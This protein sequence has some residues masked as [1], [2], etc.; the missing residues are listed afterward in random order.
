MDRLIF[1]AMSATRMLAQRQESIANNLANANTNGYR[2]QTAMTRSTQTD[3]GEVT[4]R[5]GVVDTSTGTDFRQGPLLQTGNPFDAAI[6][7]SGFFAVQTAD[8]SE[9]YTRDGQ[10]DLSAEG[11]LVSKRGYTILGEGGPL[12]IPPNH[13]VLIGRDGTVSAVPAGAGRQNAV[14]VGRL[15][16]VNP[17]VASLVRGN[18]GLFRIPNG[19]ADADPSVS[20]AA[21]A[22]EASNV[23]VIEAMVEMIG[24]A[25]Q[26][27]MQMKLIS[28]SEQNSRSASQLL[29]I[30]GGS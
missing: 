25:R 5:G 28:S 6:S 23:N 11:S 2:A 19:E 13:E 15:K 30:G 22:V 1:T 16:L 27:E 8:G 17:D 24:V 29:S 20:V 21:G 10:M 12:A 18:D 26:F 3:G 7:G 9:A 14:T 4:S